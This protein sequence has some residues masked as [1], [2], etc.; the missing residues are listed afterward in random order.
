MIT[1]GA[2]KTPENL[3][4]DIR[5]ARSITDKPV[6][7]NLSVGMCPT[8]DEMREVAIDEG[9]PVVETSGFKAVEHGKSLQ[10]AGVIWIHKVATVEHAVAAAEQGADAVVI[11]GMEGTGFKSTRQLPLS[12]SIPLAIK[13]VDVP[14]IAGGG[15][16]SGQGLVASLALGAEGVYMGTAFMATKECPIPENHKKRL[17]ELSPSDPQ[18]RDKALTPPDPEKLRKVIAKRGKI[19]QGNWLQRLELVMLKESEDATDDNYSANE[20]EITEILRIA[21]GSLAVGFIDEICTVRELINRIISE[22]EEVLTDVSLSGR[23]NNIINL[24]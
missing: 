15:I 20:L 24:I 10:G 2:L 9:V 19:E 14:V 18:I 11:V 13:Q 22:A 17:V 7:V 12:I 1:A 23:N 3:R 21:P 8:I 16:G 5:R 6:A 4:K